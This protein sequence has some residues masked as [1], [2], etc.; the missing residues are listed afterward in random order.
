MRQS[1]IKIHLSRKHAGESLSCLV[2]GCEKSFEA[3]YYLYE[4]WRTVQKNDADK[5]VEAC[6]GERGV[7]VLQRISLWTILP[8]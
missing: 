6:S 5:I 8:I 3:H 4:Y 7:L 2:K 1:K